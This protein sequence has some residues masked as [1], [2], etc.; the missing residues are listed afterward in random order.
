VKEVII[1]DKLCNFIHEFC[2]DLS[3]LELLLFFGRHPHARFNRTV[4]LHAISSKRFD[5]ALALKKLIDKKLVVTYT[6]NN[7]ALYCLTKN[8]PAHSLTAEL[9]KVGQNQWTA[10]MEK[11]LDAQDIR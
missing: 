5:T 4:V 3:V 8:E 1:E 7:L 9:L 2:D 6:E 11:I 10:I